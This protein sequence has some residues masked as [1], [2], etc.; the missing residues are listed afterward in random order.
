MV[1]LRK[2]RRESNQA[3]RHLYIAFIN[4]NIV[5]FQRFELNTSC[6]YFD[7][8]I[9]K[10]CLSVT[11][12][13]LVLIVES[14]YVR[15]QIYLLRLVVHVLQVVFVLYRLIFVGLRFSF[16][17]WNALVLVKSRLVSLFQKLLLMNL[18][19]NEIVHCIVSAIFNASKL[20]VYLWK[21]WLAFSIWS[22]IGKRV[23]LCKWLYVLVFNFFNIESEIVI[24]IG[25][26]IGGLWLPWLIYECWHWLIIYITA[27]VVDW[28]YTV[29]FSISYW[30]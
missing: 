21:L 14:I 12:T 20:V 4:K 15:W 16:V 10:G 6:S 8:I 25:D 18:V 17:A 9:F 7:G 27:L 24:L 30:A 3:F 28:K 2:K 13:V 26:Q 5:N 11:G 1:K 22:L 19:M 23:Y 29:P